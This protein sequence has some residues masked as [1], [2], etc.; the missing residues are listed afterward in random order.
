MKFLKNINN[1]QDLL[2][3]I[4]ISSNKL[5]YEQILNGHYHELK[6]INSLKFCI[7][8]KLVQLIPKN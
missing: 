2:A 5:F 6:L 7:K 4:V 8:T 3:L 1:Y